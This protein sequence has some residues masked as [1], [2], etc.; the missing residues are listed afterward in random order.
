MLG[1][2]QGLGATPLPPWGPA[3]SPPASPGAPGLRFWEE[4]SCGYSQRELLLEE[5]SVQSRIL[6]P[7]VGSGAGGTA[8]RDGIA[9]KLENGMGNVL[10][11]L[12]ELLL[13]HSPGL[14]LHATAFGS[15][16]LTL[17][18]DRVEFWLFSASHTLYC[19][20]CLR[21]WFHQDLFLLQLLFNQLHTRVQRGHCR[22][23]FQG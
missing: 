12:W 15:P 11:E 1:P 7:L 20:Y 5:E 14:G 9:W 13:Q 17:L 19:L 22:V 23:Y 6:L 3:L 10:C 8:E 2:S 21:A 18:F 16:K 4:N